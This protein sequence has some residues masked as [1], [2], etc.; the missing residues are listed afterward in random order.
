MAKVKKMVCSDFNHCSHCT[1]F[2]Q[3]FTSNYISTYRCEYKRS[4]SNFD[5]KNNQA[6]ECILGHKVLNMVLRYSGLNFVN[7]PKRGNN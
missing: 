4:S 1:L 7:G 3:P 5:V 2:R 6:I